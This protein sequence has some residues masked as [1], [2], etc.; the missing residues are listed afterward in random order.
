[1]IVEKGP[2]YLLAQR[3][4]RKLACLLLLARGERDDH[5]RDNFI[6]ASGDCVCPACDDPYWRHP[7]D[8]IEP[9]LHAL[10]DGTRVKL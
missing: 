8:P 1:M 5:L 3:F 9:Y 10:C 2:E 7:V 4:F 6:R